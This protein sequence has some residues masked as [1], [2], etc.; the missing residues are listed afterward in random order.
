MWRLRGEIDTAN[1]ADIHA[2]LIEAVIAGAGDVVLDLGDVTF[3]D[4]SGLGLLVEVAAEVHELG[5]HLTLV[6]G[7]PHVMRIFDVLHVDELLDLVET[8]GDALARL[9]DGS[10]DLEVAAA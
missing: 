5:G 3:I 9:D 1:A 8:R 2:E 10:P 4:S 7:P 6:A